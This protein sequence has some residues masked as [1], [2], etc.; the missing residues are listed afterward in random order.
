M[1]K[2][3]SA[4][5]CCTQGGVQSY[6][7]GGETYECDKQYWQQNWAN[8]QC[9]AELAN[10]CSMG[11]NLFS[12]TC[13]AWINAFQTI[14]GNKQADLIITEKCSEKENANRPECACITAVNNIN[15]DINIPI[16]FRVECVTNKCSNAAFR[17]SDQLI[18]CPEIIDCSINISDA[19]FVVNNA[20]QFTNNFVQQCGSK[21]TNNN[22]DSNTFITNTTIRYV[23]GT[24][25]GLV[26]VLIIILLIYL[27]L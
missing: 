20:D 11:N 19:N 8:H 26:V 16:G 17:T 23:I 2:Q 25:V 9:D 15:N 13:R 7:Y 27:L 3:G 4:S 14:G 24:A 6:Q 5:V 21:I 18:P 1:V 12:N 10:Y 22:T